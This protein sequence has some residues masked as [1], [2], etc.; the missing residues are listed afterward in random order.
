MRRPARHVDGA[1]GR[2]QRLADH[3]PAEDALPAGLRR[4]AAKQVHLELL[5]VEDGQQILEG[6]GHER[7][8]CHKPRRARQWYDRGRSHMSYPDLS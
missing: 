1:A 7:L 4:A 6:G 3:L 2:D 8:F 5:E